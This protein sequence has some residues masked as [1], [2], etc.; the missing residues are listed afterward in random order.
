MPYLPAI[1]TPPLPLPP[2][3]SFLL[4]YQVPS[5][6]PERNPDPEPADGLDE[7]KGEEYSVLQGVASPP[8]RLVMRSGLGVREVRGR[9]MRVRVEEGGGRREEKRVRGEG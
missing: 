8:G 7:S 5:L 9:R 1:T 3:F 2:L 4:G 6:L